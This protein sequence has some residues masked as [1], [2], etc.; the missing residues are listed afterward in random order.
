MPAG[1]VILATSNSYKATTDA[2]K[3]LR[4]DGRLVLM[5][6]S[7][8]TLEVTAELIFKR[9]RIL[10]STQN[11]P[12]HLFEALDYA[13]NGKVKVIEEIYIL[14]DIGKA[15]ERVANGQVRFRAVITN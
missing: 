1:F 5:G 15:Y 11:Q 8:E 7:S 6:A 14:D 10:G 3:G 13:A 4:P 12:E 9:G 2:L